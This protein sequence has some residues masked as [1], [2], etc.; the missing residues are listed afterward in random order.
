MKAIAKMLLKKN[1]NGGWNKIIKW[2]SKRNKR[3]LQELSLYSEK[4]VKSVKELKEMP[5]DNYTEED[6]K[7]VGR[8]SAKFKALLKQYSYKSIDSEEIEK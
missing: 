4:Y 2:K 5:K 6:I 1:K 7:K 8:F 3:F